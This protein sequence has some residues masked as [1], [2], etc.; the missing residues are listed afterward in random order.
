MTGLSD[1]LP[2]FWL[3]ATA[4]GLKL[5]SALAVFVVTWFAVRL[6]RAA[7]G[8]LAARGLDTTLIPVLGNLAA[9]ALYVVGTLVVLD[10]FGVNTTSLIALLGAA[11][12]AVGLALKNTL[13]NIAAGFML[14]F[15]RPF[16][17][18]DF[19]GF[20]DTL[21]RVR[22]VGL[23]TTE[24]DTSDGLYLSIPNG[25]LWGQ[26]LINY[27]RNPLRRVE[28]VAGIAYGDSIE[29]GLAVLRRLVAEEPRILAEPEPAFAVRALSDSS[30]DLQLRAWTARDDYWDVYWSLMHKLKPALEGEG[31]SIP[32]PQRELHIVSQPLGGGAETGAE[33]GGA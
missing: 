28:I 11:G 6:A 21:G 10:L 32:F 1:Q 26:T 17:T 15:L 13:Q 23:F 24:L 25:K 8:R 22:S 27:T 19:I 9:G 2:Q 4:L 33:T 18:G 14:L 3:L 30:V 5:L 7:L 12:L 16:Q 31:L 20:N 29:T